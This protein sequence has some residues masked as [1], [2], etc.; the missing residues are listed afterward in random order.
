MANWFQLIVRTPAERADEVAAWL[1]GAGALG[2]E[3]LDGDHLSPPPDLPAGA[4]ELRASFDAAGPQANQ[5]VAALTAELERIGLADVSE[6]ATWRWVDTQ[7]W[8]NNWKD[9]FSPVRIGRFGVHP[10]WESPDPAAR[11][12]IQ[13]D[14]GLAFGTGMHPTTRLCL[15]ALDEHLGQGRTGSVLDV[16]CGSGVLAIAAAMAGAEPVVA[17]D[18]DPE[19]CRVT[20][21]N[22]ALN[23]QADRLR[24]LPGGAEAVTDR[25]G[26]VLANILSGTL[27]GMRAALAARLEDTGV[28]VLSGLMTE[29]APA[30]LEAFG[31]CGLR[32][33]GRRDEQGWTA[34]T[35]VRAD[36][37]EGQG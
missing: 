11:W 30:V 19:A 4:A 7:D 27:I 26:L 20:A 22:A 33:A 17:V 13:I 28:L 5:L 18:N 12:S 24:V 14:P 34:L 6:P 10:G 35:L 15:A 25:F 8:A 21:Q 32:L 23:G 36:A 2:L 1:L 3:T 9:H 31:G 37:P 16:G 29:E